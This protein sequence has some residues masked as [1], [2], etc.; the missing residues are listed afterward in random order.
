[1]TKEVPEHIQRHRVSRASAALPGWAAG[2]F[3][4]AQRH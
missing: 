1:M 2:K 4:D 3:T